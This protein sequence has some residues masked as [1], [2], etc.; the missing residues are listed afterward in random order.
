MSGLKG[1]VAH[2]AVTKYKADQTSKQHYHFIYEGDGTEVVGNHTP[3]A[4]IYTGDGVY[5]AHT[6]GCNT[7]FIGVSCAAMFGANSVTDYGNFPIT[8]K[9]F[10]AMCRGIARLCKKYGIPVTTKTVL[11]HAEVQPVLGI[12][13]NGKWDI[14]VLPFA[15]LTNAKACGDLMRAKVK[16]FMA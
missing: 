11:S 6:K 14:A 4:N 12:Q 7:G 8:E 1:V 16:E 13:Q 10:L 15:K 9:Q 3:E 2:W 5:A